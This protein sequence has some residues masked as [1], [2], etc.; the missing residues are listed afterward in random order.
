MLEHP[1]VNCRYHSPVRIFTIV[2]FCL[3][4]I[5]QSQAG[6]A[7]PQHPCPMEAQAAWDM[8]DG[9]DD[10]CCNDAATALV[11]GT[12]CKTDAPC[13]STSVGILPPSGVSPPS[14]PSCSP[15]AAFPTQRYT[16]APSAVWRPPSLG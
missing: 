4:L 16:N 12:L 1:V 10:G 7:L 6:A 15:L 8:A 2:L 14:M 5:F 3:G 13:A 11:T 9:S